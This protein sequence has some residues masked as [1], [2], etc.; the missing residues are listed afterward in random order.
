MNDQS[1]PAS[2]Q[3]TVPVQTEQHFGPLAPHR[4]V[5]D[6]HSAAWHSSACPQWHICCTISMPTMTHMLH[7]QPAHNKTLPIMKHFIIGLP[8]PNAAHNETYHQPAHNKMLSLMK[9]IISLPISNAA[10]NEIYHQPAHN[11]ML[12]IMKIEMYHQAVH[13]KMLPVMKHCII[14]LPI[15]KCI[16]YQPAHNKMY[17]QA[18]HNETLHHHHFT[19]ATNHFLIL[20]FTNYYNRDKFTQ[21]SVHANLCS[22]SKIKTEA[23]CSLHLKCG[24]SEPDKKSIFVSWCG[25]IVPRCCKS[26]LLSLN[27]NYNSLW[28]PIL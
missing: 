1:I 4:L 8:I 18:V 17:H 25:K 5:L 3:R 16:I 21:E 22:A 7:H 28:S 15:T 14:S 26:P 6:T 20:F 12:S 19:A 11:K 27:Y 10:H 2:V 24:K 23:T 9:H 13:N